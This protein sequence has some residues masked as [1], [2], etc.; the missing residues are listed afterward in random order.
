V[1]LTPLFNFSSLTPF[2]S[3]LI[4]LMLLLNVLGL[5]LLSPQVNALTSG[6]FAGEVYQPPDLNNA[7][8]P[9][10]F[11]EFDFDLS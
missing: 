4:G 9:D 5:L 8:A 6:F 10:I 7:V 3:I 11:E 2:I 1:F